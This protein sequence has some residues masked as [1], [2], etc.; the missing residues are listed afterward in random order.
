MNGI[1]DHFRMKIED[2]SILIRTRLWAQIVAAMIGGL[3]LGLI[4]SP[5]GGA[6]LP[7]ATV[8]NIAAWLKLPGSIFLNLIQMVVIPL[9][10]SS[11]VLGVCGSGDTDYLKRAG[12][13]ILPYFVTTTTVAVTIGILLAL[14]IEPGNYIDGSLI[15]AVSA[16][17]IVIPTTEIAS[18][19][20]PERVANLIPTNLTEAMTTRD[21]LQIVI[22]AIIAGVA[23]AVVPRKRVQ[24]VVNLLEAV[25][26]IALKI[27]GWAMMLAPY[28]VF[29]LLADI[30]IRTGIEIILGMS[31]YVG[32][33]LLGLLILLGFYL[34]IVRTLA[35]RSL[36][37]FLI[38]IRDVQLL[39]FSTS[40]SAAV[41]PLSMRAASE[42]LRVKPAI[43]KFVIPLGATVN[44]D[45]T[46]LYQVVAALFLT[47][48]Y[49][50]EL[51]T[52]QLI[53]LTITTVGAS[54]GSPSTPGVG[55]VILATILQDIGIPASG[56]ALIIGVDR[57]LDMCRTTVNVSGDL[58]ACTVMDR[59]LAEPV[60][61]RAESREPEKTG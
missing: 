56:I 10:I 22:Y 45:G 39:A 54:I 61:A 19:P 5:E 21:M 57:I 23:I 42:R 49:G 25:Q 52:A 36:T 37:D 6:L 7:A 4:L 13:R 32:T 18:Q 8:L 15:T 53:L 59:W 28:A 9:V 27:I 41:M 34:F 29:G 24:P 47:Q 35:K 16:E 44:M 55:I 40:S 2:I 26:E 33:V 30:T 31:V 38:N 17:E 1:N 50:V 3:A 58:T 14:V 51:T 48:V 11:I 60:V 12:L 46:A 43:S 20:L